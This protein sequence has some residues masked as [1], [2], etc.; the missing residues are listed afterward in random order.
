MSFK[1]EVK[2]NKGFEDSFK[3]QTNAWQLD[4]CSKFHGMYFLYLA[5]FNKKRIIIL[6]HENISK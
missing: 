2:V 4:K 1:F 6:I 3:I 5:V